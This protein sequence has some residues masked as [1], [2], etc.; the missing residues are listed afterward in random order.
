VDAQHRLEDLTERFLADLARLRG[1]FRDLE[2]ELAAS[3]RAEQARLVVDL[4]ERVHGTASTA[5]D[6]SIDEAEARLRAASAAAERTARARIAEVARTARFR[7]ETAER[8][9]ER[10][11]RV[12]EAGERVEREMA[13]RLRE[14]ELRLL[15]TLQRAAEAAGP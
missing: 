11:R 15:E 9:E 14:A 13:Q 4:R 8:A 1:E 6:G 10:E 7:L 5:L 12:R 2:G 3:L